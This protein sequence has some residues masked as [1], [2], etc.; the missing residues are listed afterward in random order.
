MHLL[1][2]AARLTLNEFVNLSR[3]VVLYTYLPES[4]EMHMHC[5]MCHQLHSPPHR[6]AAALPS[7]LAHMFRKAVARVNVHLLTLTAYWHRS[8]LS[9]SSSVGASNLH[10]LCW[11]YR[12][13]GFEITQPQSPLQS[14]LIVVFYWSVASRSHHGVYS[15]SFVCA[16]RSCI[17]D[18]QLIYH[19]RGP[20]THQQMGR[21]SKVLFEIPI[22]FLVVQRTS[23]N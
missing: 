7:S 3:L 10:H 22:L 16:Y 14:R 1:L 21:V 18:E 5:N 9:S 20:L 13:A 23:L 19:S 4:Y 12:P 15:S 6:P 8:S 2:P 11:Q 17:F